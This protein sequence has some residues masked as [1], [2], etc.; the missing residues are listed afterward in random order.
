MNRLLEKY[1]IRKVSRKPESLKNIKDQTYD[2]CMAAIKHDGLALW[3]CKA[4]TDEICLE[5]A[6]Q[7]AEEILEYIVDNQDMKENGEE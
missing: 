5:A 1:L 4:K 2:I 7:K 3:Y 6:S